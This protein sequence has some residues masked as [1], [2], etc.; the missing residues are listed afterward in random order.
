MVLLRIMLRYQAYKRHFEDGCQNFTLDIDTLD[1]A[2]IEDFFCYMANEYELS[3]KNPAFF[4]QLLIDTQSKPIERRGSNTI[5]YQKK[6]LKVFWR[7]LL[8][9]ELTIN[10]P[11]KDLH[12]GVAVYGTPYYISTDERK[13][14]ASEDLVSDW[15]RHKDNVESGKEAKKKE[16]PLSTLLTQRDIFVFQ[17]EV[18]CRVG[19]LERLTYDNLQEGILTYIPVKTK[20]RTA[21]VVKVP[22]LD[23]ALKLIEKY[24]GKT[25]D[26]KL[27]PFIAPQK[28][29]AAIKQIFRLTGITRNVTIRD[30]KTGNEKEVPIC[31]IASSHL[32]RRTFIGN[33]YNK[34]KDPAII[35]SMSGHVEDSKA[36]A[37]YRE[38]SM[39]VK[40]E[41]IHALE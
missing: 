34:V 21:I 9:N 26:G 36:F 35:C 28:Y 4:K 8:E 7:W 30:S 17:C 31:D 19:D 22:L 12:P 2:T 29:N 23:E 1:K 3:K 38:I 6:R 16:L 14:I 25:K 10:N 40:K 5:L 32:A 41:T 11:V 24:K 39:D 37:R 20:E 33:L 18:G 13:Q 15:N 27:F